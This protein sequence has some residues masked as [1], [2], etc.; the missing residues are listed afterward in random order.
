LI[1][2][3]PH[4]YLETSHYEL[5]HGLRAF[6][7]RYGA[8]RWL[9]G[10]AFPQRYMGGA[11]HQLRQADLPESAKEAIAGGNLQRILSEVDL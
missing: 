5:A 3:Y 10:S 9:F 6:Y 2:R 11:V 1:E 7:E 8:D 4:L